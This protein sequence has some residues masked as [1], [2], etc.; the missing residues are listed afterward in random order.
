MSLFECR[1]L[2]RFKCPMRDDCFMTKILIFLSLRRVL[3]KDKEMG[4]VGMWRGRWLACSGQCLIGFLYDKN[5]KEISDG[6]ERFMQ[7]VCGK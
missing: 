6:D 1:L 5:V 2:L 3:A 7:L 4:I